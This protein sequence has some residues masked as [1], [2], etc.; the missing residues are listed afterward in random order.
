MIV[1]MDEELLVA[2]VVGE[3]QAGIDVADSIDVYVFGSDS[4]R[5]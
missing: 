2:V 1:D 5:R 4:G 3:M